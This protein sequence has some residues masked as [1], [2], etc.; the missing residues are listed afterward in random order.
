MNYPID[1]SYH[2]KFDV[3]IDGGSLEHVFNFPV[4][5]ANCMRMVKKGGSLFILTMANNHTGHG[6]YQF[7]PELFFRI[8]QME[9]GFTIRNVILEQHPF[10]GGELSPRTKCFSVA[11]PAVVKS[12]VGL[13]SNSPV[14]VMVHAIRTEITP[15]FANYPIQSD[16]A[17]IYRG[18]VE[19][20]SVRCQQAS[21]GT[22]VKN[23]LKKYYNILP[24]RCRN[25]IA[26]KYRLLCYSFFN[27][28]F[29]KRWYSF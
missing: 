3:V 16:Y 8:F 13:V 7:S 6:F 17:A 18:D 4:A 26:G 19:S 5:V 21:L 20:Q 10:P 25:L 14:M 22:F 11:D 28:R 15:V 1:P 9:N 23:T 29:Y 24:R 27:R 12:R 2:E